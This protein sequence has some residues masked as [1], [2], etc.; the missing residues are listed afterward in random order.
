MSAGINPAEKSKVQRL[1]A[2]SLFIGPPSRNASNISLHPGPKDLTTSSSR[3]PFTR[4]RSFL[5][6][7]PRKEKPEAV[8]SPTDPLISAQCGS[9]RQVLPPSK[10]EQQSNE[11]TD[12]RWAEM[13]NT[14]EE[15]ELSAT[16]GTHVFGPDHS[17]ALE[18]L[19][20][21]QIALAQAW[22][23][24]EA[25]DESSQNNTAHTQEK[26]DT[27]PTNTADVLASARAEKLDGGAANKTSASA[28][29]KTLLEEETEND[30]AL[31]R[32]RREANDKYFQR[33]NKG[34]E[35]V[36]KKLEE[37]AKAMKGVEM[38]SKE[39]WDKDSVDTASI[40]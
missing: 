27:I 2:P 10:A 12:D 7:R 23:K 36:V 15:V 25:D 35:D 33:V 38:E 26:R 30:I 21:A 16:S 1:P 14:L 22:A 18:E 31:A 9:R 17:K 19:R 11:R 6:D 20:T 13:Q 8:I 24:S 34:V 32:K 28:A 39:I 37:V 4:A 3:A 40:A 29:G 5:G